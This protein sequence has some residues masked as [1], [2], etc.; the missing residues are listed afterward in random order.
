MRNIQCRSC[1]CRYD[2]AKEGM[3][4]NCGAYNRPP[5]RETVDANGVVHHLDIAEEAT[6]ARGKVC[7]EDKVCYEKKECH[8]DP[9]RKVRRQEI[10][11]GATL[12]L[13]KLKDVGAGAAGKKKKEVKIAVILVIISLVCTIISNLAAK[14]ETVL[15]EPQDTW[16]DTEQAVEVYERSVETA[17]GTFAVVGWEIAGKA[18]TVHYTADFNPMQDGEVFVECVE[19]D[20]DHEIMLFR[21]SNYTGG[22]YNSGGT[23][24]F[25]ADTKNF[26][27]LTLCLEY[28]NETFWIDL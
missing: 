14:S 4:P 19:E 26:K 6:P 7:Y 1:G 24:T 5:K 16:Q 25:E 21:K 23:M 9:A 15:P 13:G 2:Y 12:L 8:E 22:V 27:P 11:E 3:C 17:D 20:G 10:T 28:K 18:L